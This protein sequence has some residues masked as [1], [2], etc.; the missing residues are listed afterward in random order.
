MLSRVLMSK[1]DPPERSS[2]NLPTSKGVSEENGYY[3]S[4]L[5]GNLDVY[6]YSQNTLKL[7]IKKYCHAN[8]FAQNLIHSSLGIHLS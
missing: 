5:L 8:S 3:G 2:Q 1:Q 6:R 4:F 7:I